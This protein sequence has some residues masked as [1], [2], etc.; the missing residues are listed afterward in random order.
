MLYICLSAPGV[1]QAM[2]Q[3]NGNK[4]AELRIDLVK[5][6][7]DELKQLLADK[8]I[9][10]I[11]TCRPGV[12]DEETSMQYLETAAKSGAKYIDIEIERGIEKAQRIKNACQGTN[13]KLI[14]S[15]HNF[16]ETPSAESLTEI[17]DQ[18]FENHAD[19]VK[20]ACQVNSVDDNATI[21]SM[22]NKHKNIVVFGMGSLGK[23][24]RLASLKCGAEFTYV[25]SDYGN[26]TAPGQFT[27]S[28]MKTALEMVQ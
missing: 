19:I 4:H 7:I 18:C 5:P 25:A 26:A 10:F 20:I 22:Y 17:I 28:Q 16:K 15:Y 11:V 6:S 24:T 13:C 12:F 27:Y 8:N 21:L 9:D 1:D 14:V 3:L 23:I 2:K